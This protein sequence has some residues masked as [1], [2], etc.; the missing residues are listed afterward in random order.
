[1]QYDT[2][3]VFEELNDASTYLYK[4]WLRLPDDPRLSKEITELA[5][6][7]SY[8]FDTLFLFEGAGQQIS[9]AVREELG[10]DY[11]PKALVDKAANL[12]E[13]FEEKEFMKNPTDFVKYLQFLSETEDYIG[14][15][16]L[17]AQG[18]FALTYTEA[19]IALILKYFPHQ[20]PLRI[21]EICILKLSD[22]F[23]YIY[24]TTGKVAY[25]RFASKAFFDGVAEAFERIRSEI[26]D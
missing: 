21:S 17:D 24:K 12:R 13:R 25:E 1:M 4:N 3:K 19:L 14:A 6:G 8:I 26:L 5:G 20:S 11:D 2:L 23:R 10:K 16:L 18:K 7:A 9:S 22:S 15:A